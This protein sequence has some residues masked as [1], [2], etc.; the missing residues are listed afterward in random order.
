MERTAGPLD[1]R[2]VVPQESPE[3]VSGIS[4]RNG[5]ELQDFGH[6]QHHHEPAI[7]IHGH[8]A[9]GRKGLGRNFYG[10]DDR[11][12]ARARLVCQRVLYWLLLLVNLK[13]LTI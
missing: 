4:V 10:S 2:L 13:I 8:V 11:D 9:R 3:P 7:R 6:H 1:M 12:I 5:C